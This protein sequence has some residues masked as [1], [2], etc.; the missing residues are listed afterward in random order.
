MARKKNDK[1][2][3]NDL[4]ISAQKRKDRPT[5]TTK[6]P[7]VHAGAPLVVPFVLHSLQTMC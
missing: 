4:Q 2:T 3:N 7:R 6:K 1:W 5:S